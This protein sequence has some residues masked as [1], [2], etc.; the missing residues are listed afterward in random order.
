MYQGNAYLFLN[1]FK[2]IRNDNTY[3]ALLYY[4]FTPKHCNF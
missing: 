1:T 4:S 3:E 2:T